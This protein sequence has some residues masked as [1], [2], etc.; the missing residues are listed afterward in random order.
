MIDDATLL[1]HPAVSWEAIDQQ[2]LEVVKLQDEVSTLESTSA[3][4]E[5]AIEA[6]ATVRKSMD[7]ARE[8]LK[9]FK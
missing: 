1:R 8:E 4:I 7:V 3:I 5:E 6:L 9:N 2:K